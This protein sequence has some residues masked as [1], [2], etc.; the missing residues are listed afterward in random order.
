MHWKGGIWLLVGV[1][2]SWY[3][4]EAIERLR[5]KE[6]NRRV[7]CGV[8]ILAHCRRGRERTWDENGLWSPRMLC[9]G[10]VLS[11]IKFL[12]IAAKPWKKEIFGSFKFLGVPAQNR[13]RLRKWRQWTIASGLQ[14]QWMFKNGLLKSSQERQKIGDGGYWFVFSTTP[15]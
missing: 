6:V 14:W 4:M 8:K 5:L 9:T 13:P 1:L 2:V 15:V 3:V 12:S 11:A 7:E 10:L